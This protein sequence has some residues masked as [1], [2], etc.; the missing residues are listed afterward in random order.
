[1][2]Q[3]LLERAFFETKRCATHD[4]TRPYTYGPNLNLLGQ[5]QP[6]IYGST[7]L[8]DVEALCDSKADA[9][10]LAI[11]FRQSN[12]EGDLVTAIQ[13]ARYTASA[14]IV[15][16]AAYTH[17][18]VAILD[19]LLASELP[20]VEVHLSTF[21]PVKLSAIIPIFQRRPQV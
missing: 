10:D 6:E 3:S 15:N 1:M 11:D 4:E 14:I 20:V 19:A 12:N 7:T 21:T 5:R 9:L 17:T 16:A 2:P 18:S 8:A 13:Q